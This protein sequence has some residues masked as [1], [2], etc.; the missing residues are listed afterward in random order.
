MDTNSPLLANIK[1]RI[2]PGAARQWLSADH[3]K[4]I[5]TSNIKGHRCNFR[6]K[7]YIKVIS[8]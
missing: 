6:T 1:L 3:W 2:M 5:R 4:V 7:Q 8:N